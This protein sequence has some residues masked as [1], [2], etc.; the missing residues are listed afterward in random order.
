MAP[1]QKQ[2]QKQTCFQQSAKQE[3]I[4]AECQLPACQQYGLHTEQV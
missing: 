2:N 4:S 3:G 1:D